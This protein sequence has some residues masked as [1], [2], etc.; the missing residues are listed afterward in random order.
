MDAMKLIA[1]RFTKKWKETFVHIRTYAA[2][3][4]VSHQTLTLI[5]PLMQTQALISKNYDSNQNISQ[6]FERYKHRIAQNPCL[7]RDDPYKE[8]NSHMMNLLTSPQ[9]THQPDV[10]L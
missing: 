8:N 9:S 1:N 3:K 2:F 7:K 4:E 6:A 10:S 5:T